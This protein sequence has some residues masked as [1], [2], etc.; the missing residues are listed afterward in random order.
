MELMGLAIC[1]L[2]IAVIVTVCVVASRRES[3]RTDSAA[4][5]REWSDAIR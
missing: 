4:T 5:E 1:A 3:A 2:F